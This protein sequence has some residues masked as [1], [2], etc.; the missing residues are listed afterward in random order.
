MKI[1]RLFILLIGFLLSN[2]IFAQ[3]DS[4]MTFSLAEAQNYA[5]E[6]FYMSENAKLDIIAAKKKVWETTAIGLPQVNAELNYQH[7]P[8]DIPNLNF[9]MDSLFGW[10]FGAFDR[11]GETPPDELMAGLQETAQPI[12]QRNNTTYNVMVSQL[13]FSGEYIVGLRAARSYKRL[14]EETNEKVELELKQTVANGYSMLLILQKTRN[15][16][17]K[18]LNNTIV[19]ENDTRKSYEAGLVSE[20]DADQMTLLRKKLESEINSV[21]RQLLFMENL[22]KYSIGLGIEVEIEL[23]DDMD[24]LISNCIVSDSSYV[25]FLDNSIDYKLLLT[26]EKLMKLAMDREKTKYLPTVSGFYRYSDQTNAPALDFTINHLLGVSISVPI[27]ESGSKMMKVQQARINYM[28]AQNEKEEESDK[29]TAEANQALYDYKSALE[30]YYNEKESYELSEKIL[31]KT[32]EKFN[33]GMASSIDLTTVNNQYL[34][35]QLN[36][37]LATQEL[38][39]AKVKL[40]KLYNQL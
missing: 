8:G 35:S 1:N 20:T 6:N 24:Q 38:L 15:I 22:F 27:F 9:G 10:V 39:N 33:N 16:L 40:D 12:A 13:I 18:T 21:E 11:L 36:Y 2:Q 26:Q 5:I 4:V 32:R 17:E 3:N 29:L 30:K 37:S 34:E 25:Y 14:S 19:L 7:V 23:T 28:K 31:H